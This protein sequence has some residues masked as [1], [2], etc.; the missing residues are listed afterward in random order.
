MINIDTQASRKSLKEDR[1]A[2]CPK[3]GCQTVKKLKPLKFGLFG[4]HKYPLCAEHKIHLV[5]IDEFIGDFL[6][7]INACLFD[8]SILPPKDLVNLV[9]ISSPSTFTSFFHR[10]LYCSP[11]G[12][13]VDIVHM[14][15]DSL[16]KAYLKS[17]T[18][19]Q[20]NLIND[21]VYSKKHKLIVLG[22]KKIEME[23]IEFLKNLYHLSES[24][25]QLGEIKPFAHNDRVLIRQWLETFLNNLTDRIYKLKK[26]TEEENL[27]MKKKL[28]DKILQARTCMALLGNSPS[29]IPVKVTAFE[30][31]YA[32]REF[33]DAKIC[34]KLSLTDLN[35]LEE[36]KDLELIQ[37]K[38]EI[39]NVQWEK[40]SSDWVID[41]QDSHSKPAKELAL[42][43]KREC[44]KDENPLYRHREWFSYLYQEMELSYRKIA[45][46]CNVDKGTIIHWAKK[47]EIPKR[48]VKGK[49]WIDKHGYTCVYAP[50]QYFHPELAPIDRGEGRFIRRKHRLIVEEFLFKNPQLK[51][52]KKYMIDGKYLKK[53]CVIH[54]INFN[55]LD[56]KIE[57]LWLFENQKEHHE[58]IES[59]YKCFSELI[60]L[61]KILY[62]NGKYIIKADFNISSLNV[63]DIE[64]ILRPKGENL[65]KDI[66]IVKDAIKEINWDD[67]ISDWTVKYRQNQFQPYIK[68]KLDP[69]SDCTKKNP[70]YRHRGWLNYLVNE[71]KFNLSDSRLGM[72]CGISRDKAREWRRR[73]KVSRGRNWGFKRYINKNGRI[74]VKPLNYNNPIAIKNRGWILEH[75]YIVEQN[76]NLQKSSKLANN[77][78]NEDG[79]LKSEII[80]HH[81][82]F[83]PSD[84]RFENLEILLSETIHK[85]LE[86]SLLYFVE[87]L[88]STKQ[89][90]FINGK[91]LLNF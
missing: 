22:F 20:R 4:I 86:F 28:Y 54:H 13:G 69:Y 90:K 46:I 87:E 75:R 60:K 17:L 76:L 73:L 77:C 12:R 74:F 81:K 83:D 6:K 44:S 30:L 45:N 65:Y 49:E 1:I 58:S 51:L 7:S 55:K 39:R 10:W 15:L 63:D 24:F 57:N 50:I 8:L 66:N 40:I 89:I 56:N 23:Y 70:L 78:L 29:E 82:N 16:S 61:S 52:S 14:Y 59:L 64:R 48:E 2:I 25:Y 34:Q 5:F 9:K 84:N 32:Y 91:Y 72:L 36:T 53:E 11:I 18:K 68:L 71:K 67:L 88:L 62:K 37:M 47:H 42:N 27:F 80:V 41:V 35:R 43:A 19:K 85:K 21:N 33:L 31:F 3:Y 26:S 38:N 79:F